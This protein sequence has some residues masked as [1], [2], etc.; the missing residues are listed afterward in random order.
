MVSRW[1]EVSHVEMFAKY[2]IHGKVSQPLATLGFVDRH[3][4]D[5]P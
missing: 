2:C 1:Y 3:V 5:G 4:R